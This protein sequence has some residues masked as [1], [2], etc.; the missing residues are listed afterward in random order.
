M[1]KRAKDRDLWLEEEDGVRGVE[2]AH[3]QGSSLL[4]MLRRQR[5]VEQARAAREH[6]RRYEC[7][8]VPVLSLAPRLYG[9]TSAASSHTHMSARIACETGQLLKAPPL[10]PKPYTR[11][12]FHTKLLLTK[13]LLTNLSCD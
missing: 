3:T 5:H 6:G 4:S 2:E 1:A 12:R 10:N 11:H 13:L 7:I 9:L 8:E